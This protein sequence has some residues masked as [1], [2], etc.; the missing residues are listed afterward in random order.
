MFLGDN[1]SSKSK[2]AIFKEVLTK[3]SE[4]EYEEDGDLVTCSFQYGMVK[5]EFEKSIGM[6][7]MI[8]DSMDITIYLN[9][10]QQKISV[11]PFETKK[12][13]GEMIDGSKF[14]KKFSDFLNNKNELN[15]I[16]GFERT[17]S[18]ERIKK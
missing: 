6:T 3:E 10:D 16:D 4:A 14:S 12:F 17:V 5:D 1:N 11:S 7:T 9:G 18:I 8:P 15:G 2:P 13:L